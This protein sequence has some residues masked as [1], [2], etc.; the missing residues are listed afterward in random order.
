MY[1]YKHLVIE[2]PG[3]RCGYVK[4]HFCTPSPARAGY[5]SNRFQQSGLNRAIYDT[6]NPRGRVLHFE[7]VKKQSISR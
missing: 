3:F 4:V 7:I 2:A 1:M 5:I 6:L